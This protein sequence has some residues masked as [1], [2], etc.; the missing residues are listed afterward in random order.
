MTM[1][2]NEPNQDPKNAA[3]EEI[4]GDFPEELPEEELPEEELP[5]DVQAELEKQ[6]AEDAADGEAESTDEAE[7]ADENAPPTYE[8]LESEVAALK[9]QL[10]RSLAEGENIRRRTERD[11]SDMAK[12]AITG[13]SRQII[14]VADNLKRALESVS[15]EA[16]NASEELNNL[17]I[18]IEMTDKELMNSF[19]QFNIKI[20]E[21][22]GQKFDHNLHQAMFE[23]EDLDQP[24]GTVLQEMQKGYVL[25][26]RLLRPA[27]VGV[28]KGG[29]KVEAGEAEAE[30]VEPP[31]EKAANDS[32][33]AYEKQADAA[34]QVAESGNPKLDKEL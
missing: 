31:K 11:K 12:Y 4:A 8:E 28:S 7:A 6:A 22:I 17:Y 33:S 24:A 26:D 29:P 2:E 3:D 34:D 32:S 1:N 14:S 15:E 21:S 9:D 20:I 16:R 10:L 23:I 5:A 30:V 27:M 13:F 18:G 19:E 25:H